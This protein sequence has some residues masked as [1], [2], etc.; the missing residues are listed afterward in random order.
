MPTLITGQ[1]ATNDVLAA[2]LVID[3]DTRVFAYDPPNNPY[4]RIFTKRLK[5]RPA[6]QT[7]VRWMED[8]PRPYWD[9]FAE[10][11]DNSETAIDVTNGAYW[12]IGDLLKVPSSDEVMRVTGKVS[13]NTLQVVRGYM[14]SAT[15]AS[16]GESILNLRTAQM[17]GDV[18]PEAI[19]TLK[20]EKTNYTQIW[21]T[22][23]HITNTNDA[24]AHYH[25]SEFDY[26]LRKAG[27]EH[28]RAM[29]EAA[30]H[31]RKKEDTA[32][33]ANP[34]RAAGGI[35]EHITTNVLSAGGTLTES[36]FRD[37]LGDCFRYRVSAGGR[38]AKLL[39]AGQP[40]INTI[41]SWGLNKLQ[42]NSTASQTYGMDISTY[43]AGF[44]RVEVI[45]HPLLEQGY[46]GTGYL[47]DPDGTM[48]RPLRATKLHMN[49]QDPGED[50]RKHE[51]RTEATF[52]FALEKAFGLVEGVT[53]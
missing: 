47:I 18:S 5:S 28:G 22:P 19:A 3:M 40:L 35:D 41:N 21:K 42:L 24:V 37:W 44:G 26:Q 50:G 1:S 48:F 14:G 6:K 43:E 25:G 8:E 32:S 15:A 45:Y 46:N 53:F 52:Q 36:E 10:A 34:I 27:E 9:T 11:V 30:L 4:T 29:E 31:G 16:S 7:T 38:G 2:E 39:L 23:V 17:E 33:A 49:I 20:V 12:Q 51:Y 13:T